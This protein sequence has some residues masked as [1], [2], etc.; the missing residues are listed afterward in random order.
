VRGGVGEKSEDEFRKLDR[1][2]AFGVDG[3]G[4]ATAGNVGGGG[5]EG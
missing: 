5:S 1:L 4:A 2:D 3:S